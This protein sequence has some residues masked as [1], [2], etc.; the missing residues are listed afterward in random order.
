V[1][2]CSGAIWRLLKQIKPIKSG[3]DSYAKP[4]FLIHLISSDSE[5]F[6]AKNI[7]H[8]EYFGEKI[9]AIRSNQMY[10]ELDLAQLSIQDFVSSECSGA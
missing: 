6:L 1:L 2:I 10:E 5:N 9:F 8:N 7:N 3:I 4:Y